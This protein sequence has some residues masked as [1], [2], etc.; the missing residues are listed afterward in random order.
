MWNVIAACICIS[1]SVLI[2]I[3]SLFFAF[4]IYALLDAG[5]ELGEG[6]WCGYPMQQNLMNSLSKN[7]LFSVLNKLLNY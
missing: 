1:G 2:V 3:F 5:G 7:F 6:E 4:H